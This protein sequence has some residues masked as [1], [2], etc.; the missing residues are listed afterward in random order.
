SPSGAM[1]LGVPLAIAL[2]SAPAQNVP[3]SPHS[4]ATRASAS[5]SKLRKA[6]ASASAVDRSTA[7]RTS[8]RDRMTVVTGGT[9]S[10]R[11]LMPATLHDRTLHERALHQ[12]PLGRRHAQL[13]VARP[14][15]HGVE[16]RRM[17]RLP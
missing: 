7:L 11:T 4:T 13:R 14:Q 6:S 9:A 16:R 2:R 10:M 15:V 1:R 3:W 12:R 17:D 8:G 5:A